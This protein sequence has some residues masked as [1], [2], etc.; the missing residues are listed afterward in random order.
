M[1]KAVSIT[2]T[3]DNLLWLRGQARQSGKGSMSELLDRI[4][5]DARRAGWTEVGAL[6]SVA[7]TIDVTD[8]DSNLDTADAYVR[9]L[10]AHSSRQPLLVREKK[11]AIRKSSRRSG[12]G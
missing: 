4:L 8:D 10:F 6:R 12:R 1:R 3:E 7:G 2:L 11:A 5:T 9:T